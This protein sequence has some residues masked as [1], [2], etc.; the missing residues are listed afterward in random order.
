MPKRA[1][2]NLRRPDLAS[3][4]RQGQRL[5]A[6]FRTLLGAMPPQAAGIGPL[7]RYMGFPKATCQRVVEGATGSIDGLHA[8]SR[9]PG[10]E[11]LRLFLAAC[12]RRGVDDAALAPAREAVDHYQAMLQRLGVS[13][14]GLLDAI[15][16][17]GT[18][19]RSAVT[20]DRAHAQRR[21]LFSAA[22]RV[23][24][25][26][27]DA[28]IAVG[29]ITPSPVEKGRL[30]A[31]VVSCLRGV[32]REAYARPIAATII[33]AHVDRLERLRPGSRNGD[34]DTIPVTVELL[35]EFSTTGLRAV[36]L[37]GGSARTLVTID[38]GRA[39]PA[40]GGVDAAVLFET[41]AVR[42][43]RERTDA[44]LC[45]GARITQPC[46][47]LV[48]D[49]WYHRD[50]IQHRRARGGCFSLA[51]PSG[52][53]IEGGYD[54]CWFERFP[55]ATTITGLPALDRQDR[56]ETIAS[57]LLQHICT[58]R[59][60]DPRHLVGWRQRVE[61]PLWQTEYRIYPE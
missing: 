8:F 31:V 57:R 25:E 47:V 50:L 41:D 18:S 32:I 7:A 33:P 15:A 4:E 28:K 26:N 37:E 6:A 16:A 40:R 23:T 5:I 10:V 3:L 53:T 52:D 13:N 49:V 14:R 11:A 45:A 61:Y 59:A 36:R 54:E 17:A 38:A 60:L 22:V 34:A 48:Q 27:A 51:A 9:F 29:V 46:R 21:S 55:E 39:Q 30:R 24:G 12:E 44:R 1:V 19:S 58:S 35:R 20:R 56:H 2:P 43:P 42:D